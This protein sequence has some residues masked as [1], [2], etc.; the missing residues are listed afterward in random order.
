M[1]T[2][3]SSV[4][5]YSAFDSRLVVPATVMFTSALAHTDPGSSVRILYSLVEPSPGFRMNLEKSLDAVRQGAWS[6]E[7]VVLPGAMLKAVA[8]P[9]RYPSV[10]FS[11]LLL[12]ELIPDTRVIYFDPDIVVQRNFS[13]I[14]KLPMDGIPLAAV[15][16]EGVSKFGQEFERSRQWGFIA[17]DG[18]PLPNPSDVGMTGEE[19]YFNTGMM[20]MNLDEFRTR[21]S[22]QKACEITRQ[23]PRHCPLGD[24]SVLNILAR[25]HWHRLE[26]DDNY[27][28]RTRDRIPDDRQSVTNLHF[29][30]GNKPWETAYLSEDEYFQRLAARY[31]SY[32]DLTPYRNQRPSRT[33]H[34]FRQ[35]KSKTSNLLRRVARVIAPKRAP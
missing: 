22:F 3:D 34:M 14:W 20:L 10:A 19:P 24:Q 16:D 15:A 7:E 12:A 32:L 2:K 5:I 6:V 18:L 9:T 31:Y 26:R 35:V 23:H 33:I 13:L 4:L 30:G 28:V 27:Q 8:A 11:R 21:K 17:D 25:G 1:D 29:A